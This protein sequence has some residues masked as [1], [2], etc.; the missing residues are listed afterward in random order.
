MHLELAGRVLKHQRLVALGLIACRRHVRFGARPPHADHMVARVGDSGGLLDGRG[1][2]HAPAPQQHVVGLVLA[3]GEPLRLLLDAGMRHGDC[4]EREAIE[5]GAGFERRDGLFAVGAVVIDEADLLALEL[6]HAAELFGD[7][8]DGDVGGRPVAAERNEVPHEDGAVTALRTPIAGGQQ[9]DLV[10]GHLL[11]EREGDAGRQRGEIAGSGRA[12]ALQA[13][14]ALHTLV[15]GVAGLALLRHDLDA[16]DAAVA[17]ID[18]RPVVGNAVGERNAIGCVGSRAIDQRR[19]K[20]LVL[21]RCRR[22]S[23]PS[24]RW[25]LLS[26]PEFFG[27]SFFLHCFRPQPAGF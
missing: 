16:V 21:R 13:L 17:L 10:A 5:L 11:G 22:Q 26:R 8:L 7:V 14:V 23:A 19:Q 20:L 18:E 1:V 15:G 6:V 4:L 3:N 9:R 25:R 27:S 2:H 24:L 12:F